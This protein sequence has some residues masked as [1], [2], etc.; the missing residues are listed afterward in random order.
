MRRI[1][2]RQRGSNQSGSVEQAIDFAQGITNELIR[3]DHEM[4]AIS[5]LAEGCEGV[6][7][8]L[9]NLPGCI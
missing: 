4:L 1:S 9:V 7:L 2:W 8:T 5:E 6:S 3:P